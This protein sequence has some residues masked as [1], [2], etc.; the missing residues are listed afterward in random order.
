[1]YPLI[2]HPEVEWIER[3]GYPSDMQEGD[4]VEEEFDEDAAY[5]ERR[6]AEHGW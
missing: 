1:M 2:D 6:E 5:E 3:T 4:E